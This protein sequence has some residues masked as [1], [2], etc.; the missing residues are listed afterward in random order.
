MQMMSGSC[1]QKQ[2]RTPVLHVI[3]LYLGQVTPWQVLVINMHDKLLHRQLM[4][5]HTYAV[6]AGDGLLSALH[7]KLTSHNVDCTCER[8]PCFLSHFCIERQE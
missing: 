2:G 7:L 6:P 4:F 5:N 1:G 3:C 8:S